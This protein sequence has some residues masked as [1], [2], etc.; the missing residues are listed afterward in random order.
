MWIMTFLAS[1]G[2]AIIF[3]IP[4]KNP[5]KKIRD[6]VYIKPL[7]VDVCKKM[8]T[9]KKGTMYTFSINNQLLKFRDLV[10]ITKKCTSAT[11][12][13]NVKKHSENIIDKFSFNDSP[14][15]SVEI[16]NKIEGYCKYINYILNDKRKY[17]KIDKY[18]S[19][20]MGENN[21]VWIYELREF[22][23]KL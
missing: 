2:F 15:D 4:P 16:E 1:R 13:T 9:S 20:E 23:S 3:K 22:Q 12:E 14:F 10:N 17:L 11:I 21:E 7:I 19:Y 8:V 5:D 18:Y 6:F